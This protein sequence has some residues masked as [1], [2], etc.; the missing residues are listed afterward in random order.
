MLKYSL[1]VLNALLPLL[2]LRFS[3]NFTLLS[4]QIRSLR[5]RNEQTKPGYVRS[6]SYGPVECPAEVYAK[7]NLPLFFANSFDAL[8]D[9]KVDCKAEDLTQGQHLLIMMMDTS[10]DEESQTSSVLRVYYEPPTSSTSEVGLLL[11]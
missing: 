8:V 2:C 9:F 10:L 4:Q 1:G 6:R 5:I 11:I 7:R 3:L